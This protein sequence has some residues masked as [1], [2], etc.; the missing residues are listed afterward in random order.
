[1]G[2][3]KHI[4]LHLIIAILISGLTGKSLA[5]CT[6]G[7]KISYGTFDAVSNGTNYAAYSISDPT[8]QAAPPAADINPTAFGW[9]D[10]STALGGGGGGS[11]YDG[12]YTIANTDDSYWDWNTANPISAAPGGSGNFLMVNTDGATTGAMP[13]VG[14]PVGSGYQL[15][16][17]TIATVVG[18]TYNFSVDYAQINAYGSTI[19]GVALAINGVIVQEVDLSDVCLN[20]GTPNPGW[21]NLSYSFTG[22]ATSTT[23]QLYIYA[24]GS[25]K[26]DFAFDNFSLKIPPS[27]APVEFISFNGKTYGNGNLLS[28]TTAYEINS[29]HYEIERSGDGINWQMVAKIDS[30]NSSTGYTYN[31]YD[32]ETSGNQPVYY[33]IKEVDID[34]TQ[35]HSGTISLQGSENDSFMEII[36]S[37]TQQSSTV[38]IA[39]SDDLVA[40]SVYDLL[41]NTVLSGEADSPAQNLN[42]SKL[43]TGVYIVK[44]L[45]EGGNT[46]TRKL[47]IQ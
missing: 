9:Q 42:C 31:Y 24:S 10:P 22:A 39:S 38:Q 46:S 18:C 11:G 35:M 29:S 13:A 26:N 20:C 8:A 17:N 47:I 25:N 16:N 45:F 7:E 44:G 28:W 37:L 12:F 36:P 32:P 21:Q 2:I 40:V 6:A 34:N 3:K 5:Q 4:Q 19:R 30:K 23:V 41:G 14:S 27:G 43:A 1:M 15:F 33:R